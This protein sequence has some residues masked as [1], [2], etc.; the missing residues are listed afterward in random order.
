[1]GGD[2]LGGLGLLLLAVRLGVRWLLRILVMFRLDL[3]IDSLLG[4]M[5]IA[6]VVESAQYETM[7]KC[8]FVEG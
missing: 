3:H 2:A 7:L 6:E 1:M 4:L 5:C 8:F